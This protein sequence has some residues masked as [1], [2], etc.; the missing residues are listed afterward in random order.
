MRRPILLL[1]KNEFWK[2]L[3]V[4]H[5]PLASWSWEKR[6]T[7]GAWVAPVFGIRSPSIPSLSLSA[8]SSIPPLSF[9]RTTHTHTHRERERNKHLKKINAFFVVVGQCRVVG[10]QRNKS[11]S[12]LVFFVVFL[13]VGF[14]VRNDHFSFWRGGGGSW[15]FLISR[16]MSCKLE[17]KYLKKKR[18]REGV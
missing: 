4:T 8:S 9:S 3:F 6:Q 15:D 12:N 14:L 17:I 18:E 13:V 10:K 5:S 1:Q 7:L 11:R 2:I 16:L